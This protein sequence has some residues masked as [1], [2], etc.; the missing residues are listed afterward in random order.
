LWLGSTSQ[1]TDTPD[2]FR[3]PRFLVLSRAG[4]GVPRHGSLARS[5]R[6]AV[7]EPA[8]SGFETPSD[9]PSPAFGRATV[10]GLIPEVG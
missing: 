4:H 1:T 6:R 2:E 5:P 8:E 10:G 7:I 9:A 3:G